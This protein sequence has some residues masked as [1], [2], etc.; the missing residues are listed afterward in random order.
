MGR[1]LKKLD[2]S[3]QDMCADSYCESMI[4]VFC[5]VIIHVMWLFFEN[6]TRYNTTC[7]TDHGMV[8]H[9]KD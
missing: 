6:L 1:D 3:W 7:G 2:T 4:C 5:I 8:R 9:A